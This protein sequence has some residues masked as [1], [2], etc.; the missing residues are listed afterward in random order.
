MGNGTQTLQALLLTYL[1]RTVVANRLGPVAHWSYPCLPRL[2]ALG[3]NGDENRNIAD[4]AGIC[5]GGFESGLVIV[6][7]W[8]CE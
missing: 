6:E 3:K 1:L 4:K 8:V 5:C 2:G 7:Q